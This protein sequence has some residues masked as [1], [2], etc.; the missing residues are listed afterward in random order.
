MSPLYP[1]SADM[2]VSEAFLYETIPA[3]SPSVSAED[4]GFRLSMS[5]MQATPVEVFTNLGTVR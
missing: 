4:A 2:C 3:S 1:T 5:A